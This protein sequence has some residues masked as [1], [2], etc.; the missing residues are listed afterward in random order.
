MTATARRTGT[1]AGEVPAELVVLHSLRRPDGTTKYADHMAGAAVP[2]LRPRWFGWRTALLGR[3]DV[4]HVHWPELLIRDSRRPWLRGVR[5]RMLDLLLLRLRLTRTPL[6]WTAHNLSPHEPGDAS[7]QRSLRRFARRVDLTVRLNAASPVTTGRAQ[8]TILHGH[9]RRPF[10]AHPQP[11]AEPGRVLYFGIIRPYK[12]VDTL[13]RAFAATPGADLRLRVVGNPH[14]GQAQVVR[15]AQARDPR[16]S[17][18]LRFVD[19]AELVGEI[20]RAQLVVL[21]YRGGMHNSGSLLAA[22][23]LDR[24]VLV[25]A[26]PTNAV[27]AEEAGPGWVL[28]YEGELTAEVLAG[29]L[30]ETA[31]PPAERPRLDQRDWA[32]VGRRHHAAYL[33]ARALCR[34]R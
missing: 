28:Q 20:R 24:P 30:A 22:L 31:T 32:E 16:V 19:D 23:S 9:Y 1:P 10:A 34:G 15:E 18:T 13:L 14:A 33:R 27:L 5:R 3:Y 4:L 6:V 12:G 2:G 26:S 29:A 8:E 21:P 25:P 17:S 11:A 7:E